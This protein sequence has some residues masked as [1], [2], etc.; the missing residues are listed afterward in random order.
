MCK[1]A[2]SFTTLPSGNENVDITCEISG[3][4]ITVAN[5]YGMFCEDMCGFEQEKEAYTLGMNLIQAI[6]GICERDAKKDK[7]GADVNNFIG[8]MFGLIEQGVKKNKQ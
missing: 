7:T 1:I 4:P 6:G 3:K 5:K 8:E 2:Q